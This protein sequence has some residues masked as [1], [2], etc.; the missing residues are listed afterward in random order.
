MPCGQYTVMLCLGPVI[1]SQPL[2]A[3]AWGRSQA[4]T[5]GIC[6]GLQFT[7]TVSFYHNVT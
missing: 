5:R 3:E 4:R 7:L 1:S 2:T 6:G